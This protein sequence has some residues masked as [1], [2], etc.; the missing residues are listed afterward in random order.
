MG[1]R[2]VYTQRL[3]ERVAEREMFIRLLG[4]YLNDLSLG[5]YNSLKHKDIYNL[6]IYNLFI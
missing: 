1:D 3:V 2:L 6:F 4:L 5:F